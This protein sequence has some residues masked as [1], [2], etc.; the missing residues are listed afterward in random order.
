MSRHAN[1]R[2]LGAAKFRAIL[3]S[4]LAIGLAI[5]G[6]TGLAAAPAAA[7]GIGNDNHTAVTICHATASGSNPYV[8]ITVDDDSIVTKL[9]SPNNH[10]FHQDGR[11]IIPAFDYFDEAGN[12]AHFDGQNLGTFD[13]GLPS[14]EWLLE[15][16]CSTD[17]V[18]APTL[19]IAKSAFVTGTATP[20]GSLQVGDEFDYSITV[21]N[22]GVIAASNVVLTDA[23]PASITILPGGTYP[24]GWACSL[25]GPD[26]SC[27]IESLAAGASATIVLHV[28]VAVGTSDSVTNT[29]EACADNTSPLCV[30]DDATI[31]VIRANVEIAKS[32]EGTDGFVKPGDE[33]EYTLDVRNN[34]TATATGVQVTDTLPAD[35]Q[36]IVAQLTAPAGW[37]VSSDADS[38]NLGFG[39]TVTFTPTGGELAVS[40]EWITLTIPVRAGPNIGVNTPSI[41]NVGEICADNVAECDTDDEVIESEWIA[42]EAAVVCTD[43]APYATIRYTITTHGVDL[44]ENPTATLTVGTEAQDVSLDENGSAVVTR[45]W[46]SSEDGVDVT[47]AIDGTVSE[48]I[49]NPSGED[50]IP[51]ADLTVTKTQSVGDSE[52]TGDDI[53]VRPGDLISYVLTVTN[54]G[55]KP[56]GGILTDSLPGNLTFVS[57]TPADADDWAAITEPATEVGGSIVLKL[58]DPLA[59][60][61]SKTVTVVARVVADVQ[62]MLAR[63]H[64]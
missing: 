17:G 41:E 33:F 4:A 42:V 29:A 64:G 26:L 32:S 31:T 8:V 15:N 62:G 16:G 19:T 61:D 27:T 44:E 1:Q 63:R 49:V 52:S 51:E 47:A 9:T 38:V 59:P 40:T 46:R 48:E 60:G 37:A 35:I 23:V 2:R 18:P 30:D 25:V 43:D 5:G 55:G 7:V 28:Q 12:P 3:S 10:Q 21:T 54:V 36:L 6:I 20:V 39:A 14:G 57:V 34:G 50:C 24:E 11:D 56:A 13:E 58:A 45:D 22:T 53:D